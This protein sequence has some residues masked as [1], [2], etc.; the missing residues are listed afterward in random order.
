[1]LSTKANQTDGGTDG[2]GATP[3]WGDNGTKVSTVGWCEDQTVTSPWSVREDWAACVEKYLGPADLGRL[4]RVNRSWRLGVNS[5]SDG[6]RAAEHA[7]LGALEGAAQGVPPVTAGSSSPQQR[8]PRMMR[9]LLGCPPP[10]VIE[11]G[12]GY[13]KCGFAGQLAPSCLVGNFTV[14]DRIS[15]EVQIVDVGGVVAEGASLVQFLNAA[16]FEPLHI[17]PAYHPMLV[18]L[19]SHLEA[20]TACIQGAR[21]A[22]PDARVDI[23][24]QRLVDTL[25]KQLGTPAV[26]MVCALVLRAC[27]HHMLLAPIS[28]HVDHPSVCTNAGTFS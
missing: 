20:A 7:V 18:V 5:N 14:R 21:C 23:A 3:D 17:D 24:T 6:W 26:K 1:M 11:L 8:V 12:T 4:R 28:A 25:Q 19:S 13:T 16:V 9:T 2:K 27:S 22:T 15:Q 10:L